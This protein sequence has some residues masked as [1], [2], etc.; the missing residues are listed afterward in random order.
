MILL[1]IISFLVFVYLMY[2][3]VK[4]EKF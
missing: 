3:L 4:P 1:L 2:A